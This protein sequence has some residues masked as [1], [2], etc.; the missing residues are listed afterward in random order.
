MNDLFET[1]STILGIPIEPIV[2]VVVLLPLLIYI[3]FT[4]VLQRQ[5]WTMT[6]ILTGPA[7]PFIKL[8][9][10]LLFLTS[11]GVFIMILLFL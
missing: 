9:S 11:V 2:K 4:L 10:S 8:F 5:V 6:K 3:I 1:I 7:T